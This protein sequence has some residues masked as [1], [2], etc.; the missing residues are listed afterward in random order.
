MFRPTYC[1]SGGENTPWR[2]LCRYLFPRLCL[3]LY[4]VVG[5]MNFPM[6]ET[7]TVCYFLNFKNTYHCNEHPN[8]K[9]KIKRSTINLQEESWI[10]S[11]QQKR[12]FLL[13]HI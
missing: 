11:E 10:A 2:Q 6:G 12:I 5:T 13:K 7:N 4:L 3:P 9:N 8:N 1:V